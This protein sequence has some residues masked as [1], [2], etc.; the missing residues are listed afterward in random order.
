MNLL[1]YIIIIVL[2]L[3]LT[4]GVA[5]TQPSASRI[6]MCSELLK[7]QTNAYETEN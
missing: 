2:T 6:K 4:P 1:S 5:P 7:E 3:S